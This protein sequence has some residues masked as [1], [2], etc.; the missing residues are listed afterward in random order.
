MPFRT[1]LLSLTLRRADGEAELPAME[2]P[3]VGVLREPRPAG[4]PLSTGGSPRSTPRAGWKA[5][6]F[7]QCR[8]IGTRTDGAPP[9]Q[10]HPQSRSEPRSG[11]VDSPASALPLTRP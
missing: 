6:S 9:W 11:Q 10:A 5:V 3:A 1:H 8:A 4:S 7:V 2:G